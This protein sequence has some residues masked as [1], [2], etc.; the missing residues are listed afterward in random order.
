MTMLTTTLK[1]LRTH[2]LR[3]LTTTL[4]VM[5]GVA[6][7]AGTLVLTDTLGARFD[8]MS[9]DVRAGTDVY[10]RSDTA[11][12]TM[13]GEARDR[14][15]A[16]LVDDLLGLDGVAAVEGRTSGWAQLVASDGEPIGDGLIASPQGMNWLTVDELNAFTVVEGRAPA[17]DHEV[18]IDRGSAESGGISVGDT[19]TVLTQVGPT[20]V[21]V[22]GIATVGGADSL[23]GSTTVLFTD[24]A[25]QAMV[26]QPGR[27]DGIAVVA[28]DGVNHETLAATVAEVLPAGVEALTGGELLAED[29]ANAAEGLA[30]FN[31][32]LLTFAVVA[33]GVGAFIIA[34]TFAII[35]AQRSKELAMLRAVG[36]TRRQ[37]M[38][39]VLTESVVVGA[40]ASVA[41]LVVGVGV[42]R[43]LTSLLAAFGVEL[44]PG[45]LV[46]ETGSMVTALVVG[47]LIT[48][49][50]AVLPARR[51]AKIPPVAA[52][53]DV[54]VDTSAG[55]RIR[56]ATGTAVTSLGAAGLAAGLGGV[57]EEPIALVGLGAAL[58]FLGVAVL[59]PVIARSA[60]RLIG[61]PAS[62][63][64]GV[65]GSIARENAARSPKRTAATAS[66]L[67][68]GV[69]LVGFVTILAVSVK[70]AIAVGVEDGV[71]AELVVNSDSIGAGG[72]APSLVSDLTAL[73]EVAAASG[74]RMVPALVDGQASLLGGISTDV[75]DQLF[76][77]PMVAGSIDALGT[78][79]L[80]L[81]LARADELGVQ[82]GDIVPLTFADG[83]TDD[84]VVR[85][86]FD[87]A[88]FADYLVDISLVDRH[89]PSSVEV[90]IFVALADG[91]SLAA[92]RDSVESATAAIPN[93]VV[94]DLGEYVQWQAGMLDQLLGLMYVLLALAVVIAVLGIVNTLALAIFERTRELG[95]LRALG[96][97]RRQ[98]RSAVRGE[99]VI[100][101]LLGTALGL[102][103]GTGFGWSVITALESEGMRGVSI[104]GVQ[105]AVIAVLAGLAGV[106]AAVLP[107]RRAAR[108]DVLA[109]LQTT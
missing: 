64:L 42:A 28:L 67:M 41:G 105:L 73:P 9:A 90:Q 83:V 7:M 24:A 26:G 96:M 1:G 108:I 87:S 66:A 91:V 52:M 16:G 35:V 3:L 49:V 36:A 106:V 72:F 50:S 101:A 20:E 103:I 107:A 48:V 61:W 59:G 39:S 31:A 21:T 29:Q 57:S 99:S 19:A 10:V 13:A 55:S 88:D 60:S 32:F 15:D 6:F 14:V 78:G 98:L 65:T 102:I 45:S 75:A 63:L 46:I 76:S 38:T 17:A 44:P 93:A 18:V 89:E 100:I 22:I 81:T 80:A 85:G 62:R 92:G 43:L 94:Q 74:F 47:L 69:A 56:I 40:L 5:L 97:T 71:A 25:A 37:V 95:L 51:A 27:Y 30:F 70:H 2:K 54:A 4:A 82:V 86:V 58:V 104:P 79:G 77:V 12:S 53:R 109:A 11:I 23:L 84:L 34:N 33:L 68:I 8:E